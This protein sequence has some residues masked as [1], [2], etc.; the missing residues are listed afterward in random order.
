[1]AAASGATVIVFR[2]ENAALV[3]TRFADP[4][5]ACFFFAG[6]T[7]GNR[8]AERISVINGRIRVRRLVSKVFHV[9]ALG[10]KKSL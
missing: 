3:N 10:P 6:V 9:S 2:V 7:A 5:F 8:E 4:L 1:L